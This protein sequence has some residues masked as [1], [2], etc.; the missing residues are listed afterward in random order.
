MSLKFGAPQVALVV[1]NQP[2]DAGDK[3]T[4]DQYLGREDPL[5]DG[6]TSN[7]SILAWKIPRT[8]QTGGLQFIGSQSPA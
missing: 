6:M 1:K 2:A 7:S 5:E 4:Q 3:E 8:Q